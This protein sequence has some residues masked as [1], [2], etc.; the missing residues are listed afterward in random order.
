MLE[1]VLSLVMVFFILF[2]LFLLLT[3]SKEITH[4]FD[5]HGRMWNAQGILSLILKM[6]FTSSNNPIGVHEAILSAESN[7]L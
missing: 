4:G 7:A 1:L 3:S 5:N 2:V 6:I